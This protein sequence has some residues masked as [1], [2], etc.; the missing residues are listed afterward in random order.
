MFFSPFTLDL[1]DKTSMTRSHALSHYGATPAPSFD[2][3]HHHPNHHA[4]VASNASPHHMRSWTA[5]SDVN[6]LRAREFD[7]GYGCVRA[8]VRASERGF[9]MSVEP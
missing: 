5:F 4:V 7:D 9:R 6:D 8:C 3:H 1:G 2:P